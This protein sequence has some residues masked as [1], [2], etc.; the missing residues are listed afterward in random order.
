MVLRS[1]HHGI[2]CWVPSR[3]ILI[4]TVI[5]HTT[6]AS[7]VET[8]LL[9][10]KISLSNQSLERMHTKLRPLCFVVVGEVGWGHGTP[11]VKRVFRIVITG[12]PV[13]AGGDVID[14]R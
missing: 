5:S 4:R 13:A 1:R 10:L 14:V 8:C 12:L 6:L 9:T 7:S 3:W 11:N 2:Q